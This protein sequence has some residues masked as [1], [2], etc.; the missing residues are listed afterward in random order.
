LETDDSGA[1]DEALSPDGD[2]P[3]ASDEVEVVS[4]DEEKNSNKLET[5]LLNTWLPRG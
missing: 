1:P 2:D 5:K 3:N 4:D